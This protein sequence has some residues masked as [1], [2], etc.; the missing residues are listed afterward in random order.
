MR[1]RDWDANY[2]PG[3]RAIT[4]TLSRTKKL[5]R[6]IA[7][8]APDIDAVRFAPPDSLEQ[9]MS[10]S[11]LQGT[12]VSRQAAL[13]ESFFLGL[14]L[15]RGVRLLELAAN[16]GEEAVANARATEAEFVKAGLM[17]RRDDY[18][19]LTARGRLLSNEVF[20]R[21][22]LADEIAR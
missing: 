1:I 20:E 12:V 7:S 22:I 18:V 13:E 21:F 8:A 15:R 16:F 11:L 10:G 17:E 4:H 5:R 2:W 9:Y 14:R 19:C 6:I 3:E